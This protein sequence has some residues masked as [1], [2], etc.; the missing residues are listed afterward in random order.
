MQSQ[1]KTENSASIMQQNAAVSWYVICH[2]QHTFTVGYICF[3]IA[4]TVSGEHDA[5]SFFL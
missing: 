4:A 2:R 1:T 3:R 5:A